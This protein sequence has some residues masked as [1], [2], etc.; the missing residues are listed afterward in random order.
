MPLPLSRLSVFVGAVLGVAIA[1]LV[2]GAARADWPQWRGPTGTGVADAGGVPTRWSRGGGVAWRTPL[3]GPAGSTPVVAGDRVFLTT[4]DGNALKLQA[5][6]TGDGALTWERVVSTGDRAVR[7]DEGNLASPSPVTDGSVVVALMGD[8]KMRCY[9][10]DGSPVWG[11]DLQRR[12]GAFDIA[13]G[14]T[15]T[16]VLHEGKLYVQ[17]IHGDGD[18]STHEA[19]VACL[20]L[21][22]GNEVW[23]ADRVTGA[24]RE[25]EHAYTSPLVVKLGTGGRGAAAELITH[26]ADFVVAYDL[27]D[28]SER[29]RLGGMNPPGN[30]HPTFRFVA[31]PAAGDGVLIVPTAKRGPVYAVRPGGAGD[32]TGAGRVAWTLNRST[33]DVPTP[34]VHGGLVY[35]CGENG[36]LT[37]VDAV[38]GEVV[39]RKRVVADR[40]RASPI[41][42]DGKLFMTSRR[43][44]VNVVRA[45]RDYELLASNEMGEPI[46]S[47][48]V[49][50]GG[51][52]YLRTFDALYAVRD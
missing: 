6:A 16:P 34:L 23:S 42:A 20:D 25:C 30:Y 4:A 48:P 35:L 26:G 12:Y 17:M 8:G 36:T 45:G 49:V 52:I 2:G 11:V 47:T 13:F 31:S 28:G 14:Y 27:A 19:R 44:L 32:V 24:S 50:A 7:G 9:R 21:A 39:Y 41:L 5:Y 22:T 51:T 38:S 46:S 40:H 1:C 15:S 33:P 43:G 18:P 37:T 10:V 29:W 3:P